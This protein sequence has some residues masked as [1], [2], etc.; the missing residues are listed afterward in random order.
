APMPM[1]QAPFG[2]PSTK[3]IP[4]SDSTAKNPARNRRG[5][6]AWTANPPA[7]R[8]STGKN[9]FWPSRSNRET[10]RST[11]ASSRHTSANARS[12][13]V[14]VPGCFSIA[15]LEEGRRD[16]GSGVA[17]RARA[18][19]VLTGTGRHLLRQEPGQGGDRRV[20]LEG[21]LAEA[22]AQPGLQVGGQRH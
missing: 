2:Q 6:Q 22:V 14:K 16:C 19:A 15:G 4:A 17:G 5:N 18:V 7:A 20:L 10:T 11:R 13:S 9:G 8:H 12:R 21:V 1:T 3:R